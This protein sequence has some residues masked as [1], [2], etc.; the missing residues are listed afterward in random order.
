MG[1]YG[2]ILGFLLLSFYVIVFM[3]YG[4]PIIMA[5]SYIVLGVISK[6]FYRYITTF[7]KF[8]ISMGITLLINMSFYKNI[9]FWLTVL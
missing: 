7:R 9:G 3:G 1:E 4:A 6:Y 2:E 8:F 5:I